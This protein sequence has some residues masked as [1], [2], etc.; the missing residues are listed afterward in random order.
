MTKDQVLA[1]K[2][3][4]VLDM[5]IAK[6]VMGFIPIGKSNWWLYP[7][8]FNCEPDKATS[9]VIEA[10]NGVEFRG[11]KYVKPIYISDFA[12]YIQNAWAVVKKMSDMGYSMVLDN[13]DYRGHYSV[14]FYVDDVT[15][16]EATG[17]TAPEAI[18]KA[19]LLA[20]IEA[21]Q[22]NDEDDQ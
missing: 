2:P 3:G 12:R 17:E 7:E 16:S 10:E 4:R 20:L 18:C 6:D 15:L 5:M 1:I 14:G 9:W 11:K 19:A 8:S 13:N 22:R 21:N